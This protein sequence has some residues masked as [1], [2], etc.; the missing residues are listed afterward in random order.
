MIKILSPISQFDEVEDVIAA[1]ADELYCGILLD[2]WRNRFTVSASL[3]RRQEDNT[4]LG[5]SPHFKSFEEL[6]E[7]IEVA[8]SHDV[9]VILTLNEHY[10]SQDQYS[11]LMLY[12]D[13]ALKAGVDAFIMG[14]IA[15]I[16]SMKERGIDVTTHISTAGTAFNS[17]TVKF[18][19][20]LGASRIILPRHLAIEE[21]ESIARETSDIELEAFILNSRCANID[22]FCT[23]Q[24]GL[25]D[26]FPDEKVKEQYLNACMLP[27]NVSVYADNEREFDP[28]SKE[29]ISWE[30]QS[31]W[32]A[33][34]I[35]DRPCGACAL[36]EFRQMGL[37]GVKIVGR[38]N[39]KSK[40]VK[41]ATFIRTLINVLSEKNPSKEEFRKFSRRLYQETY[42]WPCLVFKCYYPSVLYT[43]E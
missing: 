15:F 12:V 24:H 38:Q 21:I 35:D 11:Y 17:E 29:K 20:E 42:Q 1:G 26:L 41:D 32:S 39:A 34:H 30:R 10:Y 25:A 18:Y 8:H 43:I 22:G 19:R 16:L 2:N 6:K 33:L 36:Y 40:K 27:Y 23:F 37:H 5:T 13:E 9:P 3:N 31:I 14:D 28:T 7:S 4:I